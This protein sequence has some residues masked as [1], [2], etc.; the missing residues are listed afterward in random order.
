MLWEFKLEHPFVDAPAKPRPSARGVMPTAY[1][2]LHRPCCGM[3]PR[4]LGPF[5]SHG[6]VPRN[7]AAR[8][9][10]PPLATAHLVPIRVLVVVDKRIT[11]SSA[12]TFQPNSRKQPRLR[13][14][15]PLAVRLVKRN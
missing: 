13:C 6:L 2:Y 15:R 3:F 8:F 5:G 12:V 14:L 9:V 1:H 11:E 10:W 4:F 7:N